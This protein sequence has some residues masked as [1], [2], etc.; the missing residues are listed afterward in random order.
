MMRIASGVL[1]VA[2]AAT[3]KPLTTTEYHG[4]RSVF[5]QPKTNDDGT[6]A[7]TSTVRLDHTAALAPTGLELGPTSSGIFIPCNDP[8]KLFVDVVTNDDSVVWMAFG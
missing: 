8:S 6:P 2:A 3:P 5:V 4:C 7:N 1:V